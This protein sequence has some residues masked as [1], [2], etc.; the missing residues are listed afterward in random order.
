MQSRSIQH[1]T[2]QHG[3]ERE[4]ETEEE[5]GREMCSLPLGNNVL[6]NIL[7][8]NLYWIEGHVREQYE[9]TCSSPKATFTDHFI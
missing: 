9:H 8:I 3:R 2:R 1:S 7:K 5:G 4:R 6:I